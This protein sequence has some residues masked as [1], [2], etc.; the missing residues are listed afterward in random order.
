MS[1]QNVPENNLTLN[2]NLHP[3]TQKPGQSKSPSENFNVIEMFISKHSNES[4]IETFKPQFISTSTK[5]LKKMDGVSP[6]QTL[7]KIKQCWKQI[8]FPS[9]AINTSK[10]SES[11]NS[12]LSLNLVVS[13]ITLLEPNTPDTLSKKCLQ[14]IS[15]TTKQSVS[16]NKIGVIEIT[17]TKQ[18]L[19]T[20]KLL[21][22]IS[23]LKENERKKINIHL[24]PPEKSE[25]NELNKLIHKYGKFADT[26]TLRACITSDE[27]FEQLIKNCPDLNK[28]HIKSSTIKN[29]TAVSD[30]AF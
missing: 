7:K 17:I 20:A 3:Q 29:I 25:I 24:S 2:N 26:L 19:E 1:L 28:L 18:N 30:R 8:L 21:K 5:I 13:L 4:W 14:F 9:Q 15:E 16:L 22:W 23:S 27:H 6:D 12:H 10:T 11:Q